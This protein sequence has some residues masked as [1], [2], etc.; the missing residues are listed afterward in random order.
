MYAPVYLEWLRDGKWCRI[1]WIA[2]NPESAADLKCHAQALARTGD[3]GDRYRLCS[4]DEK[5]ETIVKEEFT[6]PS[7]AV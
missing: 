4:T 3:P 6:S 2:D 1:G 5:G 7:V